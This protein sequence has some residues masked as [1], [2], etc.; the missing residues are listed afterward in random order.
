MFGRFALALFPITIVGI[1]CIVV[2]E[3]RAADVAC[4]AA[5]CIYKHCRHAIGNSIHMC[6]SNCLIDIEENKKR[7]FASREAVYLLVLA[8]GKM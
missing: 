7:S 3:V 4:D 8:V 2:S 5:A 1:A 6:N